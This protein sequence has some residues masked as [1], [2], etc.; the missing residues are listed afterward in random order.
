MRLASIITAAVIFSAPGASAQELAPML[1][2]GSLMLITQNV[3]KVEIRYERPRAGL[4]VASGTM[5]FTGVRDPKGS[6]SGT[7]YTFKKNCDPA[8]FTVTGSVSDR[9]IIL[10]G[11]APRRNPNSCDVIGAAIVPSRLVFEYEGD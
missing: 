4:P 5:L 8:P 6:Y 7:A 10:V 1:H 2:N 11:L 3:E 9:G